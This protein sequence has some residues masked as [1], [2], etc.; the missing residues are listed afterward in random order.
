MTAVW[1]QPPPGSRRGSLARAVALGGGLVRTVAGVGLLLRPHT[2]PTALGVDSVTAHRVAWVTR[3]VAGRELAL[4]GATLHALVTGRRLGPLLMA[5]A[6]SDAVDV[7]ALLAAIRDRQV[8]TPRALAGVSA[9]AL[10][11]ASQV[12]ARGDDH[13]TTA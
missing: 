10:A 2:L 9:A 6:A 5:Q 8:S 13:D 12:L 4:G 11:V 3:L 1:L 7:A